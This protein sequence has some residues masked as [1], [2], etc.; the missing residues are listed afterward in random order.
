[1]EYTSSGRSTRPVARSKGL[2]RRFLSERRLVFDVFWLVVERIL[3]ISIFLE[4]PVGVELEAISLLGI[5]VR[6]AVVGRW[7]GRLVLV[8]DN[9]FAIDL[10]I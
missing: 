1:M 9:I 2:S 5:L 10:A 4:E 3:G 6:G 7:W 8:L